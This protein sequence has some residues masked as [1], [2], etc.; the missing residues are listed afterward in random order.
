MI[1]YNLVYVE[2]FLKSL[3]KFSK[4]EQK[5][6][7]KKLDLL[8][9]NPFYKSLRTKKYWGLDNVFEMSVNMDI[10]VFWKYENNN[11]IL[12]LNIG[13]HDLL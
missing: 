5:L 9:Q 2:T 12:L 3:K 7:A 1:R 8:A 10:R 13:H 11:I 6:I 4:E